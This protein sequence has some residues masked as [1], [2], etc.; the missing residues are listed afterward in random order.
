M[1]SSALPYSVPQE[2]GRWRAITLAVI[3]HAVLFTFLWVGIR[4]QSDT[5]ETVEAEVWSPVV[6]EAAPPPVPQPEPQPAPVV[7]EQPPAVKEAPVEQP[8][9]ALEQKKKKRLEEEKEAREEEKTKEEKAKEQ[10]AADEKKEAE[11]EKKLADEKKRKQDALEA[12]KL[13][14]LRQMDLKRM[15][16]TTDATGSSG[17]ATKSQGSQK[18][19]GWQS[20]VAAKVKSNIIFAASADVEGNVPAEFVVGLLPDGSVAGVRQTKS[21]GIPGFDEAVRRAIDKS[22]PYPADSSGRVPSSFVSSNRPKDQ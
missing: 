15:T 16:A 6:R 11:N 22:Q 19:A 4:W 5:P 13:A 18:N 8:D 7:K 1:I 2:P 21:S 9:I 14:E 3:V 12:K 10:Q 17:T 20:R